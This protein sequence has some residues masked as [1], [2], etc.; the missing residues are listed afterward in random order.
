MLAMI[1]FL[2]KF[3]N[4]GFAGVSSFVLMSISVWLLIAVMAIFFCR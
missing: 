3:A 1:P 2:S 4:I